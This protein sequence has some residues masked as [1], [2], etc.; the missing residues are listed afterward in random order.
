MDVPLTIQ[1]MEK[2]LIVQFRT[3]SL[4]DPIALE[5]IADAVYPLVDEQDQ[6]HMI[7]DFEQVEF[8]S[9]QA[10]GIVLTLKKKLGALPHSTLVLCGVGP[11]LMELIK[12]TRLDKVL[13]IRPTQKEAL[14]V[15]PD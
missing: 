10:I 3:P 2:W 13:K 15:L 9:S 1:E 4:M 5:K 6:R 11:R 7:L 12:I 14:K 8:I